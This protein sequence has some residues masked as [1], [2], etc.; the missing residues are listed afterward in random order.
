MHKAKRFILGTDV[1]KTMIGAIAGYF[2]HLI[3]HGYKTTC[4]YPDRPLKIDKKCWCVFAYS[5]EVPKDVIRFIN[6]YK[7]R[8]KINLILSERALYSLSQKMRES[9]SA[10]IISPGNDNDMQTKMERFD[11]SEDQR[12][13]VIQR[14]GWVMRKL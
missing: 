8:T 4:I 5:E 11:G 10:Q 13:F 14:L 3:V 1:Y 6:L 9:L 12:L 2:E 7:F